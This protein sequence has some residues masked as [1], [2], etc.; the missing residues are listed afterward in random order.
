MA[1]PPFNINQALPGDSDIV[2]QHPTNA[3]AFRDVVESWLLIDGNTSGTHDK[4][5]IAEVGSDPTFSTAHAGLW[6]RAG[7]LKY[8]DEG[9]AITLVAT[10]KAALDAEI[11]LKETIVNVALKA[12]L[13]SPT[14]TG[15]PLA[16]T[17][18]AGTSTTQIA[19][20]AYVQTEIAKV[21]TALLHVQDQKSSGTDGGSFTQG[22][23][24]TRTLN[25]V[26]TNEISG[27][28]LGSNQITLPAGTFDI[29]A[30][31][32]AL[33]TGSSIQARIFN[34]SDASE[35]VVGLTDRTGSG[36][37]VTDIQ[38][39]VSGR[40]TL[41]TSKVITLQHR[42]SVT[43]NTTGFGLGAG[44]GTEVFADVKIWT[45]G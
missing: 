6:N 1:S 28:S 10:D 18:A 33:G 26:V 31:A 2:S 8:R 22:D 3:R 38:S 20:T 12:P 7:V 11:A 37:V 35:I 15:T 41:A 43:Q 16:P 32:I 17:A 5:S 19:T 13:A 39:Y 25:T 27:A 9:G 14:F 40:F 21:R 23:W 42:I 45:I 24:R 36:A 44:F 4:V 30:R 34:V 29:E